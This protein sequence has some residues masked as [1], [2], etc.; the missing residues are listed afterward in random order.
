M[1]NCYLWLLASRSINGLSTQSLFHL[2][3]QSTSRSLIR[4]PLNSF[5]LNLDST[6][7]FLIQL[8]DQ[9]ERQQNATALQRSDRSLDKESPPIK[10]QDTAGQYSN[11]ATSSRLTPSTSP[12]RSYQGNE[13][14]QLF[15]FFTECWSIWKLPFRPF[16][17]R[18]SQK[19]PYS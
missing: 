6:T 18:A 10:P 1:T 4:Y 11:T 15:N 17:N 9:P 8:A 12:S 3:C 13:I 2:T 14:V 5:F 7:T 16:F 19:L